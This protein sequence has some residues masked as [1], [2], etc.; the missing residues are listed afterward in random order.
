[1]QR[2][3]GTWDYFLE[4]YDGEILETKRNITIMEAKALFA[5]N[6]IEF[7]DGTMAIWHPCEPY[8]GYD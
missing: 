7:P 3:N 1:M 8:R 2:F 5:Q 4:S 6:P